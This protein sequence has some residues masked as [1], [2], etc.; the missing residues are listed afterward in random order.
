MEMPMNTAEMPNLMSMMQ[1]PMMQ[2]PMMS[3]VMM[4]RADCEMT[5][6]GMVLTLRP[7]GGSQWE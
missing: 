2:M 4:T 6:D 1:M 3:P 7:M 5:K